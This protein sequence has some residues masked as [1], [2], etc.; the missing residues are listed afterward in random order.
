MATSSDATRS[1]RDP[2][3]AFAHRVNHALRGD[4]QALRDALEGMAAQVAAPGNPEVQRHALADMERALAHLERRTLDIAF[5]TL[6][7]AGEIGAYLQLQPLKVA[8]LDATQAARPHATR[9]KLRLVCDVSV[10]AGVRARIDY[11]LMLRALAALLNNAIRFSPLGGNITLTATHVGG[12]GRY[13]VRDEGEGFVAGD[14][15]RVLA[16]FEVGANEQSGREDGLG[17]GLAVA[18]AIALAHG[19]R[20]FVV[21]DGTP[22]AAVA[23]ELPLA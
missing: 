1:E 20:V 17:L 23:I 4:I 14:A 16:P 8:A 3:R 18:Q 2:Q 10:C 21:E 11:D 7:D 15:A 22:G 6:A 9:L 13:I 5:L 12:M 19:G